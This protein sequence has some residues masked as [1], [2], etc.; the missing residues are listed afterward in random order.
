[1]LIENQSQ[2]LY[3][4]ISAWWHLFSPPADY[5]EEAAFYKKIFLEYSSQPPN[6]ILELGSGGGNNASFLKK[7]FQMTLVDLSPEMLKVSQQ[8]NPQCEHIQG[9]M[10]TLR[11]DR[12]F[13]GVFIHDAVMYITTHDDLRKVMKTAFVHCKPGG[14]ALITPDWVKE[15]FRPSTDHGGTD[16]DSRG[17][18]Y[19][20]WTYDPD[21]SD[22][23]YIVEFAILLHEPGKDTQIKYDR[24]IFGLFERETWLEL[25]QEAGFKSRMIKDQDER[26]LFIGVKS[27]IA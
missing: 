13:D 22:T 14:V 9:D 2:K 20:E 10:R 15:T 21:P 3:S 27:L 12:T 5:E 26:D 6:T 4:E 24:H 23:T 7:D 8:L 16:G 1:M 25:L 11:L 18:R 17:I 19:L